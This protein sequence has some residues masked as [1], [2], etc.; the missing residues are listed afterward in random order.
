MGKAWTSQEDNVIREKYS[1]VTAID[2]TSLLPTRTEIAIRTRAVRLG[3][4]GLLPSEERFWASVQKTDNCWEWMGSK[5]K[6]GYG[7]FS[8]QGHKDD[9]AHRFSWE[10]ANG[11]SIPSGS[12][13]LHKCD[14]PSCV[15]PDHLF[16]GT[17]Q[18]NVDDMW[19]KGRGRC[20]ENSASHKLTDEQVRQI[21]QRK[22][23]GESA[24]SLAEEYKVHYVYIFRLVRQERRK[25]ALTEGYSSEDSLKR[26]DTQEKQ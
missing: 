16:L 24:R 14:N 21:I 7:R 13:I 26:V 18:D 9:Y 19:A 15:R 4:R 2:L 25:T 12:L 22:K 10:L 11:E 6:K 17:Y 1:I 20:G 23:A 5:V 3:V 8:Y